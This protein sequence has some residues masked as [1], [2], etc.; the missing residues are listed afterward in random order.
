MGLYTSSWFTVYIALRRKGVYKLLILSEVIVLSP[1]SSPS[2]RLGHPPSSG[3]GTIRTAMMVP[4][5]RHRALSCLRPRNEQSHQPQRHG[6]VASFLSLSKRSWPR[7][8]LCHTRYFQKSRLVEV[9]VFLHV[10]T[11]NGKWVRVS[12]SLSGVAKPGDQA[13]PK[14]TQL[15]RFQMNRGVAT[16][17]W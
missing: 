8:P 3:L 17:P 4:W 13:N 1:C 14:E 11:E 9:D 2:A 7:W 12:L 6:S 5:R 16:R 10:C 15:H